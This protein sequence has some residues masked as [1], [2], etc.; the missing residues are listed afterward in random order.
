MTDQKTKEALDR[1]A[2]T[3]DGAILYRH[4]QETLCSLSPPSADDPSWGALRGNEGRR[5]FAADLMALMAEGIDASV[6]SQPFIAA[7]RE[8]ASPGRKP[9]AREWIAA[10]P[11]WLEPAGQ[12][13]PAAGGTGTA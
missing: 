9:T 1:I 3:P 10:Q 2:R 11:S 6:R 8:S 5:S 12:P 7:K 13:D 4:L